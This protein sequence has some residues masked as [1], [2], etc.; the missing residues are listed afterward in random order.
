EEMTATIEKT[1]QYAFLIKDSSPVVPPNP[2]VSQ[3]VP[4][5]AAGSIPTEITTKLDF[6]PAAIY[7]GDIA[8]VLLTINSK[9]APGT[10]AAVSSGAPVQARIKEKYETLSGATTTYV[11]YTADLTA[12]NYGGSSTEVEFYLSANTRVDL[13]WLKE[14]RIQ[15]DL[16]RYSAGTLGMVVGAEGGTVS[17]DGGAEI[18]IEPGSLDVDSPVAVSIQKAD[19]AELSSKVP[20]PSGFEMIGA[21]DLSLGGAQLLK[22]GI[23]SLPLTQEQLNSIPADAQ[24]LVVKLEKIDVDLCW[25][26]TSQG[27]VDS[28]RIKSWID[29]SNGLP[30][31]GVKQGGT[32]LFLQALS[33][34]GFITGT[35]TKESN[36][37]SG[38]VVSI[39][40]ANN[41]DIKAISA[42]TYVQAGFLGDLELTARDLA[43]RDEGS[44]SVVIENKGDIVTLNLNILKTGPQVLSIT[45]E[46][47][48]TGVPL[49]SKIT[50]IFSEPINAATFNEQTV[51]IK[52]NEKLLQGVQGDGFLEKSPPGIFKLSSDGKQGEFVPH[53]DFPSDTSINITV[54]TNLKD[55]QGNSLSAVFSSSFR[56]LD[57]VPP[58]ADL[59]K[60][61]VYMPE[62]G[63]SSIIGEAGSVEPGSTVIIFNERTGK[64]VTVTVLSDGSFSASIDAEV[65][66]KIIVR[67]LDAAGNET[68]LDNKPFVSADGK[69][70]VLGSQAAE[71]VSSEGLGIK[72]QE[73]TFIEPTNIGLYE[74]TDP[75]ILAPEPQ[76]FQRLKALT[77][78]FSGKTA[79]KP[80]DISI[81]VPAG[82]TAA[83]A[84]KIFFAREV[85]VFGQ[86]RVMVIDA[87]VITNG[88]IYTACE[89][90]ED[91]TR[92]IDGTIS[93]LRATFN[94]TIA[95]ISGTVAGYNTVVLA[96]ELAYI[97]DNYYYVFPVPVNNQVNIVVKDLHTADTIYEKTTAGP[98]MAGQ[99]YNFE[100][101]IDQ[102]DKEPPMIVKSTG[103]LT[104]GFDVTG[105]TI[106]NQGITVIPQPDDNG[107]VSSIIIQGAAGTAATK[108]EGDPVGTPYATI[109]VYKLQKPENS[110]RFEYVEVK[111]FT[112]D[113][114]G[115]FPKLADGEEIESIPAKQGDRI[116]VTVEKGGIPLNQE[117]VLSFSE[118]LDISYENDGVP[119]SIYEYLENDQTGNEIPIK[120]ELLEVGGR[121]TGTEVIVKLENQLDENQVYVLKTQDNLGNGLL[122]RAG[123]QLKISCNFRA[124]RSYRLFEET[125]THDVLDTLVIGGRMFVASG[126]EGIR[127]F[128]VSNPSDIRTITNYKNFAGKVQG[129]AKYRKDENSPYQLIV[130]G[131]GSASL[132]FIKVLDISNLSNIVQL[133]SQIISD[134]LTGSV[135][136]PQGHPRY[137]QVLGQY[138][139]VTVRGAGLAVVD[140]EGMTAQSNQYNLNAIIRYHHEDF[141][142]ESAAYQRLIKDPNNPQDP[143][144]QQVLAVVLVNN[145]G[146]KILDMN[147]QANEDPNSPYTKYSMLEVG[148]YQLDVT[149][150]NQ[151]GGLV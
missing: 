29:I 98:S 36:P 23:I 118:P 45:P 46:S 85:E 139:F 21:L 4:S 9:T 53:E 124:K 11:P 119:I 60:I 52:Y 136:L 19:L 3:P 131:G 146:I 24:L 75:S 148:T 122:D 35:V 28:G 89:P 102:S 114:N 132:G 64:A 151:L 69:R 32:Y 128:D 123:N 113:G 94:N 57:L 26:L 78:D 96:G 25:V 27:I 34:M 14:G 38:A 81:T 2:V 8:R 95:F 107:Q 141:I 100:K 31:T 5:V 109:R 76:D 111:T 86:K 116:T 88:R 16:V 77:L 87:A 48:A 104:F 30:F 10:A 121:V 33:P 54:T 41:Q 47:N 105:Q 61:T 120:A 66:D 135:K 91:G 147:R 84:G 12:Y 74:I 63:A 39:T 140:I 93:I 112:A 137:V 1:G 42:G 73:G 6:Y 20:M 40:S 150:Q 101:V 51:Y 83:D 65:T 90:F 59:S 17:G 56:T 110:D 115:S 138:A 126:F 144:K 44:G 134:N 62:N 43:A 97:P 127:I 71:F 15:S 67:V 70:V 143:G 129:L 13:S 99:V 49:N 145:Y 79:R 18:T 80:V 106:S 82:I 133:K 149:L 7:P 68:V 142:S 130:V 103:I 92:Q 125:G 55:L 37:V 72:I 22:P 58:V 50:F 117:F 108:R